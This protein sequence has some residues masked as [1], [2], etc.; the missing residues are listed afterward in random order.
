MKSRVDS[1]LEFDA[2]DGQ[3]YREYHPDLEKAALDYFRSLLNQLVVSSGDPRTTRVTAIRE[4]V[5]SLAESDQCD[6]GS[7]GLSAS[8]VAVLKAKL[9][10]N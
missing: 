6:L 7:Y 2:E 1:P 9:S 10:P 5:E 4:I 3:P 8:E